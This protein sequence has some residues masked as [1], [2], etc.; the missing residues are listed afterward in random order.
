MHS[1]IIS[2]D[3][4]KNVFEV[5]VA[6]HQHRI[7]S[8]H[9]L[10]RPKFAKFLADH[11]PATVLFESCG[12]AHYWAR[13][14]IDAGHHP[15]II[16]PNTSNPT[17][18]AINLTAS[19]PK[20]SSKPIVAKASNPSQFEAS[21]NNKSNNFIASAN[22]G[23]AP[24]T[25][26]SMRCV[27]SCENSATPSPKGRDGELPGPLASAYSI[28]LDEVIELEQRIKHIELEIHNLTKHRDDVRRLRQVTGIGLLTSTAFVACAGSPHHFKSGRHFSSWV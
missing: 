5:A 14:A 27:G 25:P 18:V 20:P 28:L 22:N 11:E 16:P 21:N 1:K 4:A 10:S 19:T 3:L 24:A 26:A 17:D 23:R 6:N 8:R 7:V 9:R 2:V 15:A 12:T 13:Q